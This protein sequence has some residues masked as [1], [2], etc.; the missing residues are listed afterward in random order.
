MLS[1]HEHNEITRVPEILDALQRGENVA[2]VSD[3]GTPLVCDPGYR[4]V[5]A[6]VEAGIS[7]AP[8][9]G[10]SAA[11]TALTGSGLPTDEFWFI[12]FLPPKSA[13]R[14][15]TLSQIA[16]HPGTVIVY[17]SPHRILETLEDMA[18]LLQDRPVVLARE[19]TKLYE[20][21]IRGTAGEIRETLIRNHSA[22]GEMTLLIGKRDPHE[23]DLDAEAEIARLEQDGVARM[24]AIKAVAKRMGLP[25]REVYRLA[26]GQGNNRPDKSRD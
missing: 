10:A 25:K 23:P 26:A 19:L 1:Y 14:R 24:D 7:V 12:G 21:F 3:A 18:D 2:L 6:A 17:E 5:A 11:I 9:P 20:E 13:A 22:R 8:L 16:K 4:I 15:N